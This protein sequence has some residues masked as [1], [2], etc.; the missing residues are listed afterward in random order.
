MKYFFDF[1]N[2]LCHTI[3][4]DYFESIPNEPRIKQVNALFDDGHHI[5]IYTAR[6]MGTCHENGKEAKKLW[7]SLT[8]NQLEAWGVK[9]ETLHF[10]KPSFDVLIDDKAVHPKDFFKTDETV[11]VVAGAFPVFHPGYAHMFREIN[12][13]CD[14]IIVCLQQDPSIERPEKAKPAVRWEDRYQIMKE[15]K[16]VEQ[17]SVYK[18]EMD[19]HYLLSGLNRKHRIIRFLGDDYRHKDY[20]GKHLNLR[21]MFISRITGWSSTK[22]INEIKNG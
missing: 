20:T 1:D 19:L 21:T 16:G 22:F 12:K 10:G 7:E 3:G 2:T 17:V 8:R 6:G 5:A 15:I 13:I 14:K 9:Y 11:G 18:T 4:N